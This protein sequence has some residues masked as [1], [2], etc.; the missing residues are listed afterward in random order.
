MRTHRLTVRYNIILQDDGNWRFQAW[1]SE[2]DYVSSKIF[3]YQHLP[4]MPYE[5]SSR[6]VFVNIAQP[7]DL[8]EYPEDSVGNVFPFFRK[9]YID[10]TFEDPE[11][12]KE[13]IA[14]IQGDLADLC[15]ALNRTS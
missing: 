13:T 3:V 4:D 6:D 8:A 9:S 11:M 12:M 5:E 7:A 10:L 15:I 1:V 14:K 2:T